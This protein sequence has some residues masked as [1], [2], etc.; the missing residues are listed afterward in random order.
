ME[1]FLLTGATGLLGRYLLRDLTLADIPL[2]VVVRATKWESARQRVETAMAHWEKELGRALLRPVVLEGDISEPGLGLSDLDLAW[3]QKH[4]GSVIHSAASLTF[5][6]EE[7]DGEPYRSNVQGTRNVLEL[8]RRAGIRRY[9]HVSTAYVC[10]LR[11]GKILESDLDVGQQLGNDYEK[12]KLAAEKEVLATDFLD[13]VTVYRPSIIVGDSQTGFTTSYHGFYTPLRIVFSLLQSVPWDM[14]VQGDWLGRL[15]LAGNERKNL[16]SV[17]WV[18]AAM[19]QLIA[20]PECHGQTYH[21]TNPQPVT[22]MD[23]QQA[24]GNVLGERFSQQPPRLNAISEDFV[25]SFRDQMGIYQSYWSDDPEFDSSRTQRALPDLPC[26]VIDTQVMDRLARYAI[27]A[28]F[29]WPREAQAIA[30]Q[31]IHERLRGW[32][33]QSATEMAEEE[34]TSPVR[35]INLRVSGPGGGA[36]LLSV[37]AGRLCRVEAG[38]SHAANATCYVTAATMAALLDGNIGLDAALQDGRF[39][40]VG[41]GVHPQEIGRVLRQ[42]AAGAEE[43]HFQKTTIG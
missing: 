39:V 29:G 19:T 16:V 25:A 41:T 18:S 24:I 10:G 21:L 27:T 26:P 23:M 6:A 28:N 43:Q 32:L 9:H 17:E 7:A 33:E 38:F 1:Y 8:C 11:R 31:D 5:H 12:T 35:Q 2:A 22:A 3:V 34:S 4:C 42:C 40:M 15:Q 13:I 30:P 36:W 37:A 20:R 14:L